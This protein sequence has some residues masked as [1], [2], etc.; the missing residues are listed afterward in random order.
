MKK[1]YKKPLVVSYDVA[2]KYTIAV[3]SIVGLAEEEAEHVESNPAGD[4]LAKVRDVL[5]GLW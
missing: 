2:T 3:G 1:N 5:D 4:A